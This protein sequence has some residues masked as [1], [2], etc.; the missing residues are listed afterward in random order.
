MYSTR[1]ALSFT[2]IPTDPSESA[3]LC[4]T[5]IYGRLRVQGTGFF[6]SSESKQVRVFTALHVVTGLDH[7]D[8]NEAEID[9]KE[10]FIL[11]FHIERSNEIYSHKFSWEHVRV[12][13]NSRETDIAAIDLVLPANV[14]K[15]V[16]Q[17]G[18]LS[19]VLIKTDLDLQETRSPLESIV[20]F[21]YPHELWDLQSL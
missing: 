9:L 20:M 5:P 1:M 8:F 21:G 12:P 7:Y 6:F 4:T 18:V 15:D 19:H 16:Y 3:Y 2:Q 17:R 10:E 11:E 14:H 13:D